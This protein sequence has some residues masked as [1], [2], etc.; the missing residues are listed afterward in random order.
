VVKP[1]ITPSIWGKVLIIPKLKLEYDAT[2]LF[3]P[4]EQLV[5]SIKRNKDNISG[6]I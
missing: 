6:C 1:I 5:P 4:G 3:G 2:I